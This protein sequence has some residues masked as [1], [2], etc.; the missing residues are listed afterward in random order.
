VDTVRLVLAGVAVAAAF[1]VAAPAQAAL[2]AAPALPVQQTL[3]SASSTAASATSTAAAAASAVQQQAT[4]VQQQATKGIAAAKQAAPPVA[5]PPATRLP[6]VT[7]PR[8]APP[9]ASRV[10][11]PAPPAPVDTS[12]VQGVG[13]ETSDIRKKLVQPPVEVPRMGPVDDVLVLLG[14]TLRSIAPQVGALLAPVEPL[15]GDL[16]GIGRFDFPALVAVVSPEKAQTLRAGHGVLAAPP[17]RG[18]PP[19]ALGRPA[20]LAPPAASAPAQTSQAASAKPPAAE[21]GGRPVSPPPRTAPAPVA[22]GATA[23]FASGGIFVPFLGLLV[24]A[25]LAAPRLMRRLD[26]LPAF[27]RPAPFLCALERPG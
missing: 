3:D 11:L 24:L 9:A 1:V 15:L 21:V 19:A 8:V 2:P 13:R 20:A 6:H 14:N 12:A 22:G 5:P 25:A 23:L 17:M 26:E 18:V 27:V 10:T 7:V 4:K 16:R